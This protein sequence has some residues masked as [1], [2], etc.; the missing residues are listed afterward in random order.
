[1][2]TFDTLCRAPLGASDYIALQEE[3]HTLILS[4]IPRMGPDEQNEAKRFVTLID[5]LYDHRVNLICS[6]AA[7]PEDLYKKGVG[8]FEFRR[9]ASRLKEMQSTDYISRSHRL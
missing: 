6:A 7:N 1:M 5:V 3:F 2:V 8:A 4:N 9:T